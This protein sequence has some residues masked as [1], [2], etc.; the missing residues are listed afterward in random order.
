MANYLGTYIVFSQ[1]FAFSYTAPP[2]TT[3]QERGEEQPSSALAAVALF[4][5]LSAV[6]FTR[7]AVLSG[8]G[9]G[10]AALGLAL[11]PALGLPLPDMP[12]TRRPMRDGGLPAASLPCL[13]PQA[14]VVGSLCITQK[15]V[16][17]A[18]HTAPMP[19]TS[20][21]LHPLAGQRGAPT[22]LP[23]LR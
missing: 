20:F 13:S 15:R 17:Q 4:L 22:L 1:R 2:Y 12:A 11:A 14:C 3:V 19:A 10:G 9:G 7:S 6:L 16:L 18:L 23:A 21:S 5:R 8:G